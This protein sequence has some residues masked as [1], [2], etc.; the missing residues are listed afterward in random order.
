MIDLM[1][2]TIRLPFGLQRH[3]EAASST[4]L[5]ATEGPVVDFS[6]PHGEA[7]LVPPDSVSWRIFKNPVSLFVGGVAAVILELADP[8]VRTGVW[9]RSTFRSDPVGRLRRTGLAAMVTVYGARSVALPMIARIAR[10][11]ARVTGTTA[12]GRPYAANDP[13][14]LTWVHVTATFGFVEAYSRYVSGLGQADRDSVYRE[15]AP[16]L[17]L[18]GAAGAPA[19]E[20]AAGALFDSH[21]SR[22]EP[23]PIVFQFLQMMAETPALPPALA[24]IQPLLVR[25]AVELIPA[26]AR[27]RLGLHSRHALRRHE[28]W[29]VESAA[30]L[31]DR[32]VLREGPASQSCVRLGLPATFLYPGAH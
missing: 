8:D 6:R 29:I 23:S 16:T 5:N 28:R 27:E 25:A 15:G 14:L 3:L 21:R 26:W 9:E 32:I 1:P 30:A 24:W 10:M 12:D 2:A 31:A 18:Y 11:H 7:A 20:R 17:A 4:F 13:A 19:S 22:L